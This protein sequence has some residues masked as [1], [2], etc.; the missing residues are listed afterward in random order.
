MHQNL[1]LVG[2]PKRWTQMVG[3]WASASGLL[4]DVGELPGL[5][6]QGLLGTV[7]AEQDLELAVGAGG[8]PVGFLVFGRVGAEVQVD[9]AVG[10]GL[11][12]GLW[13]ERPSR[14]AL[15]R[16]VWVWRS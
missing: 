2:L 8:N 5:V 15:R 12:P 4:G 7:E 1:V 9:Q 3:R 10:I 14:G 13:E 6:E 16:K 11:E